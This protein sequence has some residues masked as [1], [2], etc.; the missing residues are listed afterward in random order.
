MELTLQA[1]D[2]YSSSKSVDELWSLILTSLERFLSCESEEGIDEDLFNKLMSILVKQI[3][4]LETRPEYMDSMI[5]RLVPTLLQL[6]IAGKSDALWKPLNQH[7]LLKSRSDTV[8]VRL[9]CLMIVK[10]FYGQIGQDFL[11]LLP[12]TI[13]FLAELMED[14]DG[15][16]ERLTQ[17]VCATIQE[18]L[19]EDLQQYFDA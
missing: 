18:H 17:E 13:P 5:E 12:E 2:D 11:V 14:S 7:V 8:Q 15:E 16:V 9:L 6:A 1:M 10:E 19:G 4:T 3:Q